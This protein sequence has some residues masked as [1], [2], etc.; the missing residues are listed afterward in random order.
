M[1]DVDALAR[2][3]SKGCGCAARARR[4]RPRLKLEDVHAK[5]TVIGYAQHSRAGHPRV[6]VR[7]ACGGHTVVEE[8]AIRSGRVRSCGCHEVRTEASALSDRIAPQV[9]LAIN[10]LYRTYKSNAS[11]RKREFSIS[12]LDFRALVL[13]ACYYCGTPPSRPVVLKARKWQDA[14]PTLCSGIDR[15]VSTVGYLLDNCVP[16]CWACNRMKLDTPHDAFMA[17]VFAI[18]RLHSGT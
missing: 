9:A 3:L 11:Q 8:S 5:L 18:S 1:V 15:K 4:T 6:Q 7:C 16:C 13:A 10:G 2:G 17:R 14:T 12:L